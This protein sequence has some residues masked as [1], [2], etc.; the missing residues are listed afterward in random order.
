M[1]EHAARIKQRKEHVKRKQKGFQ[2]AQYAKIALQL[3]QGN[4]VAGINT[5]KD[6]KKKVRDPV[7]AVMKG[8]AR[9]QRQRG[10]KVGRRRGLPPAL[11][12]VRLNVKRIVMY[13]KTTGTEHRWYYQIPL[14]LFT[15]SFTAT[16][17][18]FKVVSMSVKYV[19]NNS[20]SETGLY[21]AVLLDRDGFGSYGA[22]TAAQWFAYIGNMPGS[23]IHP[24]HAPSTH[25]W[26]PT[27]PSV[28][29]WFNKDQVSVTLATI[30]ICNNGKETEEL[31]GL[32]EI[33]ATLLSRGRF[34]NAAIS[35]PPSMQPLGTHPQPPDERMSV[36]C[37]CDQDRPQRALSRASSQASLVGGFVAM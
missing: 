16:F 1:S 14:S 28:K 17:Q 6:L 19:P 9:R 8:K 27:E 7:A 31:G 34:W 20:L 33:R 35:D 11:R 25:R 15:A 18:E 22:A 5:L 4:Y 23:V 12:P 2:A 21:T 36:Q 13:E 37:T 10:R 29:D 30:Y 26:R 24:R 32:L 3:G